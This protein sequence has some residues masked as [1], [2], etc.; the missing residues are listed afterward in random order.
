VVQI[1][2]PTVRIGS[3]GSGVAPDLLNARSVVYSA[4]VEPLS[5]FERALVDRF[6]CSVHAFEHAPGQGGLHGQDVVRP[7]RERHS[8][9][10]QPVLDRVMALMRQRGHRHI[11]LLRL[12]LEGAEY[13]TIDAL[14]RCEL[15]PCQLIV[16]FHH[17]LPHLSLAHT[18]R[19]LTQLN[20]LGYRI[21]DC[22]PSGHEYSL[23]L[24]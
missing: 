22:Q 14:A 10:A 6:G 1:A 18:E 21:F 17:H 5:S 4:R 8:I 9:P 19:A 15:R 7:A 23:A 3:S 16:D 12:D 20:E 11:D 13:A 2:L 24:V